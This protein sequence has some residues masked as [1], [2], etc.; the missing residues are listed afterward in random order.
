MKEQITKE[1]LRGV[2]QNVVYYNDSNDYAVLEISDEND[3]L[4]TAVG[5][6]PIPFEGENVILTGTWIYHKDFGKQFSIDTCEKT[7]PKE[8]EG[9]LQYLSSRVV[10]GLGPVTAKKIVNRFGTDT[11]DVIQT[12]P[13]WLA[14]IPGIT[15]KKAAAISKSFIEQNGLREVIMFCNNYMTVEQASKVYKRLG[16]GAVGIIVENPY[17]LCEGEYGINFNQADEIARSVG[18]APDNAHRINSGF[19]YIFKYNAEVNGHTCLPYDKLAAATAEAL[20]L[21]LDTVEARLLSEIKDGNLSVYSHADQTLV[22]TSEVAETEAYIAKRLLDIE[23][24]VARFDRYD[25]A[26]MVE[27]IESSHGIVYEKMQKKAIHEALVGG[28]TVITGGPGTGKTTIVKA[29]IAIFAQLSLKVVLAAPTGRAA[30]RMSEATSYEA[31]TIHRMLEME[32]GADNE[33]R[34]GR[35]IL[36]PIDEKV[37][38][39]DE[40]SMIDTELMHALLRALPRGARLVLI[41]DSNQLPS[42]GAGNVLSDIIES[43][44]VRTVKLTEI[45]RQSQESLI[46][47]NAHS[48]NDG[49]IPNLSSVTGDFFFVRRDF[50]RDIPSTIADLITTRLPKKYGRSITAGIQ[51]ITPS[52]K[53]FGGSFAL[54]AELQARINPKSAEK[55]EKS[56][57]GTLFRE[58]DKVMQI[59]NNYEIEWE[60]GHVTGI[61]VFNGDIGTVISID[62]AASIMKVRF[63]DKIA[64]Y[65]FDLLDELELAYAITVHKSQGSE[66]PVVIMPSYSCAPMLMTRNLLYTAVTRA[67]SMVILV[68]RVDAISRMVENN[69]EILRYTTLRWRIGGGSSQI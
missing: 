22:M 15:M 1:S 57:H 9:I 46:V 28:V 25:I 49:K 35:G 51:V 33:T 21:P 44:A 54:N 43:G 3:L 13:E 23:Y 65:T 52:K 37:C 58:G 47:T 61:G 34:F 56:A 29:L 24:G 30:K 68:G 69:S 18:F 27:K 11:F 14:D 32:R 17:L 6:V 63:D 53:G 7:L 36:N 40:A 38:I 45:F 66:Y 50:E 5:T 12:H 64:T 19:R 62:N 55:A 42:V 31:K 41:G 20:E 10:K 48:I 26:S 8:E 16:S 4:I 67:K 59:V 60:R 39:V 2:I